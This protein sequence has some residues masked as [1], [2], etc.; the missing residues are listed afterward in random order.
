M[1]RRFYRSRTQRVLGGVCGGLGEYFNLDPTLLRLAFVILAFIKG[2]GIV[3]YLAM[4]LVFPRQVPEEKPDKENNNSEAQAEKEEPLFRPRPQR[5]YWLGLLLII[6]GLI[7]LFNNLVGYLSSLGL[8]PIHFA[9]WPII[10][11]TWPLLLILSG[12]IVLVIRR[13]K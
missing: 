5:G 6:L 9:W 1:V 7:S 13:G 12:I 11:D 3:A 8:L 2:L 10:I 4:W